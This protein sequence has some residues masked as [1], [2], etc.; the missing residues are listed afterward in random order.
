MGM[1]ETVLMFGVVLLMA[2]P[3]PAQEPMDFTIG[4]DVGAQIQTRAQARSW[5]EGVAEGAAKARVTA[6]ESY[7]KWMLLEPE[8]GKWDF[9]YYDILDEST[10]AKGWLKDYKVLFWLAGRM[11]E[12]ST[13][14]AMEAW[15]RKGGYLVIGFDNPSTVEGEYWKA[16]LAKIETVRF[17]LNASIG[18]LQASVDDAPRGFFT[19][20]VRDKLY[21]TR[22]K[23][24]SRLVLNY[25]SEPK[26]VEGQ[27]LE[28]NRI[29]EGTV[30]EP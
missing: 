12:Q 11:T 15:A 28:P 23:D 29:L 16:R 8:R 6:F 27:I 14:E 24:G 13:L 3:M 2:G 9:S 1:R 18:Q 10:I 17:L 5:M 26:M 21:H 7:V 30:Q 19:D 4:N 25:G 20:G 22:F